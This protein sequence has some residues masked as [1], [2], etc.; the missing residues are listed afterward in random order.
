MVSPTSLGLLILTL[1]IKFKNEFYSIHPPPP[2][3]NH[4]LAFFS[5]FFLLFFRM[6]GA[7]GAITGIVPS[8]LLCALAP[9]GARARDALCAQS[10]AHTTG[11]PRCS[12]LWLVVPTL[13]PSLLVPSRAV[14]DLGS[15]GR[16][17]AFSDP[18]SSEPC[19]RAGNEASASEHRSD[20]AG[21]HCAPFMFCLFCLL[22]FYLEVCLLFSL[23]EPL[24]HPPSISTYFL[25]FL[26]QYKQQ[27][28]INEQQNAEF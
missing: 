19:D 17:P 14:S 9:R 2:P 22:M 7:I 11:A 25:S 8:P 15:R 23:S 3:S 13:R 27:R 24:L 12:S 10:R 28:K 5:F 4:V 26:L 18:C 1:Q 21:L 20:R 16:R 6:F